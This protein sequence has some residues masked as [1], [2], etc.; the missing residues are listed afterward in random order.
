VSLTGARADLKNTKSFGKQKFFVLPIFRPFELA[1]Y[2]KNVPIFAHIYIERHMWAFPSQNPLTVQT[3]KNEEGGDTVNTEVRF[4]RVGDVA[5]VLGISRRTAAT[6]WR[7][8]DFPGIILSQK[9]RVVNEEEFMQ[10]L[11]QHRRS[12]QQ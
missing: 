12:K 3:G 4:L 1:T 9:L 5:R 2:K 11:E 6:L 8:E 7:R 10:W